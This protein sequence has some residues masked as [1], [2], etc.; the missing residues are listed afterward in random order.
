METKRNRKERIA[1]NPQGSQIPVATHNP[2]LVCGSGGANIQYDVRHTK[3]KNKKKDHDR[4]IKIQ[5]AK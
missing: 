3:T 2:F 1:K 5:T 4:N